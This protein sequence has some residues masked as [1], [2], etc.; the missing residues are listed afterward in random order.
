MFFLSFSTAT[1]K[2]VAKQSLAVPDTLTT[3]DEKVA[4]PELWHAE[5]SSYHLAS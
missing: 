4:M 2:R 3:K 5:S 1:G